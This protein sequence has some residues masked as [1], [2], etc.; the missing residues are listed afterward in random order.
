MQDKIL[1]FLKTAP[2]YI[3]GEEISGH[4]KIS[5]Q[6]L[7][8]HIQELKDSGYDVVAVPHL[9]YKL[10]SSPD[11][12]SSYEITHGLNTKF[13]G[14][15][16]YY[17]DVVS[18]TMD[19]AFELAIKGAHEG[20]VVVAESQTK[21]RGRLGRAWVSPKYKGIYFTLILRPKIL[22]NQMP[23]LTL[24]SAVSICEAIKEKTG[25]VPQIKWPNDIL[26]HH[27]KIGG[28]LTELNAETD[29]SRFVVI[30][31]GLNVNNDKD[32]L[33]IGATSL[34]EQKKHDISRLELLQEILRKLEDNYL[35]FQKDGGKA[36]IHKWRQWNISL[37][38]RVRVA[39]QKQHVEGQA[40]NIDADGGLL[41]RTDH[42]LI[43][44]VMAGD[45]V[46][47]R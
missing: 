35:V 30:G 1:N 16:S 47:C 22:P 8:K 9:G 41:V 12:L 29:L 11:R 42:G 31:M 2:G 17:F 38:R 14:K 20:A 44:K 5:R 36:I 27:K 10:V 26:I 43:L 28:I 45:V 46:H 6:A 3:S 21:G 24:M 32:G 37:G 15:K 23:L 4:L 34:R 40:I 39:F 7:W 25:L 19:A 13:I 33:P 18:S